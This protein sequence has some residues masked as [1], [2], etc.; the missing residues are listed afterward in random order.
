MNLESQLLVSNYLYGLGDGFRFSLA[1]K[2][3]RFVSTLSK[4][5]VPSWLGTLK[6]GKDNLTVLLQIDDWDFNTLPSLYI[7]MPLPSHW[8]KLLPIAHLGPIPKQWQG[9]QYLAL[10]YSLN[11]AYD[12]TRRDPVHIVEWALFTKAKSVLESL[13][14]DEKFRRMELLREIKPFWESMFVFQYFKFLDDEVK[15]RGKKNNLF[16]EDQLVFDAPLAICS[17]SKKS[18]KYK[19]KWINFLLKPQKYI[20]FTTSIFAINLQKETKIPSFKPLLDDIQRENTFG[21]RLSVFVRWWERWDKSSYQMFVEHLLNRWESKSNYLLACIIVQGQP[22]AFSIS[23]QGLRA[24]SI[25]TSRLKKELLGKAVISYLDLSNVFVHL[26]INLSPEFVYRRSLKNMNQLNLEGKKIALVGCGAIGGYLG[27]SLARLGAG[28]LGG[29]LCLIDPDSMG[30]QNLGRHALGMATLGHQKAEALQVEIQHQLPALNIKHFNT[31]VLDA[32][33]LEEIQS[34]DL[35]IDATAKMTVSETLNER[36][37]LWPVL[38]RPTLLHVWIRANGECVQGLLVNPDSPYACRSC[39]QQAGH[40]INEDYD[41]MRGH[42]AV[43]AFLACSDYTP[44]A[45][46]AA[47]SASALACDMVLDWV[48]NRFSPRYRTRYGER[49]QGEKLSSMDV[50]K[51]QSCHVCNVSTARE[52]C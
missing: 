36:C 50:L 12:L 35:I 23:L 48:S 16:R 26:S 14:N 6:I 38:T 11:D 17:P 31:S 45:V 34:Y 39:L 5:D 19:L 27:L 51:S 40:S 1:S 52:A 15:K 7:K 47:M 28:A 2:P 4:E 8:Q 22:L 46:S 10:C 33:V 3:T 25:T 42:Q 43:A 9:Q 30:E 32:A 20:D 21:I 13:F 49:W 18:P 41:A 37:H 24:S 44:Y 29:Q